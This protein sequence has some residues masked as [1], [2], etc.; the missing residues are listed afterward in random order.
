MGFLAF[1]WTPDS[2]FFRTCPPAGHRNES[3][4]IHRQ[5]PADQCMPRRNWSWNVPP[6][7]PPP[8][9][10]DIGQAFPAD[11][12]APAASHSSAP[13]A[14]PAMIRWLAR[15]SSFLFFLFSY[16][17]RRL[18]DVVVN[19]K[20]RESVLVLINHVLLLQVWGVAW[21]C[22]CTRMHAP[23]PTHRRSLSNRNSGYMFSSTSVRRVVGARHSGLISAHPH[24]LPHAMQRI[25]RR[26]LMHA[27]RSLWS[28]TAD[29][30]FG[31][32]PTRSDVSLSL[33]RENF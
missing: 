21:H 17:D 2:A 15:A 32:V 11:A 27:R 12:V 25:L 13:R 31:R 3:S 9:P 19:H 20:D 29:R 5:Q 10:W 33:L 6:A 26:S 18:H 24:H 22:A 16:R 14:R 4:L 30:P 8:W 7:R 23:T 28:C 1:V